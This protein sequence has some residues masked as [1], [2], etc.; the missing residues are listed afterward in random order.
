MI[1][2]IRITGPRR[3]C[4][5][6]SNDQVRKIRSIKFVLQMNSV[7]HFYRLSLRGVDQ[8]FQNGWFAY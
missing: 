3:L 7:R 5:S 8:T 6:S 1:R 2:M 4:R